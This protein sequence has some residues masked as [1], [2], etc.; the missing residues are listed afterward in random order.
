[1]VPMTTISVSTQK[2]FQPLMELEFNITVSFQQLMT[3]EGLWETVASY[4]NPKVIFWYIG[5]HGLKK[6]GVLYYKEDFSAIRSLR[7][8]SE[9]ILYD[10]TTWAALSNKRASLKKS[11]PNVDRINKWGVQTRVHALAS[12]RFFQWL[13]MPQPSDIQRDLIR[14]L[15]DRDFIYEKSKGRKPSG[16]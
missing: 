10:L 2:S 6:E 11:N 16:I 15:S 12:S 14:I 5:A 1:M 3:R 4:N 9:C 7:N 13:Q 8:Q